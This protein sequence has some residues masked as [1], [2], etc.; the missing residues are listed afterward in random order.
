MHYSIFSRYDFRVYNTPNGR[1]MKVLDKHL[2][3]EGDVITR[4][5][6]IYF[7]IVKVYNNSDA[8]KYIDELNK[9]EDA[10]L[11]AINEYCD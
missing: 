6:N 4:Y 2:K 9:N 7:P 3:I 11:A 8:Q 10:Y 1:A 5:G